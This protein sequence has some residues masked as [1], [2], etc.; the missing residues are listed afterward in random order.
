MVNSIISMVSCVFITALLIVV[1]NP[2]AHKIDLIDIPSDRKH[3]LHSVPLVGGISMAVG[4]LLSI[5]LIPISLQPYRE[6][7]FGIGMVQ[8]LMT[9]TCSLTL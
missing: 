3:H 8:L 7:F 9:H 5:V 4:I 6:L 1:L 2:I